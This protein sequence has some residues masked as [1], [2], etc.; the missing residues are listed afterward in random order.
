MTGSNALAIGVSFGGSAASPAA[1]TGSNIEFSAASSVFQSNN[2]QN[3]VSVNNTTTIDG[4]FALA[5]GTAVASGFTV[6]GTGKIIFNGDASAMT[7]ATTATGSATLVINNNWG[8][9]LKV[10]SSSALIQLGGSLVSGTATVSAGVLQLGSTN[11]LANAAVVVNAANGLQ[12]S[13]GIG[14]FNVASLSGTQGFALTDGTSGPVTLFVG[15]TDVSSTYAGGMSGTGGLTK[16][17]TGTLT[18]SASSTYNGGTTVNGGTLKI[19]N[20]NALGSGGVSINTAGRLVLT[21]SS[22]IALDTSAL[23]LSGSGQLDLTTNAMVI[24][25]ASG[26]T[27]AQVAALVQSGQNNGPNAYWDGP[28][29]NSAAAA[30]DPNGATAVGFLDNSQWGYTKVNGSHFGDVGSVTLDGT[31]A[32]ILLKYTYLGDA[33]LDG[34][35]NSDDALQYLGGLGGA[36]ATW[37]NGDFNNDGL[38]NSDD[39]LAYLGGQAAYNSGGGLG[40]GGGGG[41]G[42]GAPAAVPEPGTDALLVLG[43]GGLALLMRGRRKPVRA[44]NQTC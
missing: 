22:N 24:R 3:T 33:N 41:G 29:I 4:A 32:D 13:P 40:G 27:L 23:T 25:A 35:V 7:L 5:T 10:V 16:T 11:A 6:T 9:P 36:P 38:V 31:S 12:F 42:G 18:L 15:A 17:G 21:A 39:A 43:A 14:T 1:L 34:V 19:S 20:K 28:G 8:G 30:N 2:T 44:G 26:K 37:L